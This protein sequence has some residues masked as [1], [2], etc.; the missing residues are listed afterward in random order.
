[1]LI[2]GEEPDEYL[3]TWRRAAAAVAQASPEGREIT[4]E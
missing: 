1:V 4:Q 2:A 3:G